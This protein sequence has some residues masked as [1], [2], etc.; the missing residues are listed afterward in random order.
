VTRTDFETEGLLYQMGRPP[1]GVDILTSVDGVRFS[2]VWDRR[3]DTGS[4][5]ERLEQL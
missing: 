4:D 2:E 5:V 3:V 1:V